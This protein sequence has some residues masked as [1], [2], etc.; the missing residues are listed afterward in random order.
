VARFL[1]EDLAAHGVLTATL[2]AYATAD[3]SP[4]AAAAALHCHVNTVHNRLARIATAT[5]RDPRRFR[6]VSEL[7]VARR[8]VHA[9]PGPPTE[10]A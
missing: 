2:E 8:L 9:P 6:D 3:F 1:R 7:L 4:T 10:R 5:G